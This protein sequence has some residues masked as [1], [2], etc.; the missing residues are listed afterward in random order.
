MPGKKGFTMPVIGIF[1]IR[2]VIALLQDMEK[3]RVYH[4]ITKQDIDTV[5]QKAIAAQ[6]IG[7]TAEHPYDGKVCKS[8]Y[9]ICQQ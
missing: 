6:Q 8:E 7:S 5:V 2:V 1:S 9:C 4:M 3:D